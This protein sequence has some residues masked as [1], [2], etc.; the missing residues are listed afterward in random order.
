MGGVQGRGPVSYGI[1]L[2]V[3]VIL[4]ASVSE[5]DPRCPPPS[6]TIGMRLAGG[7]VNPGRR[8]AYIRIETKAGHG[9]GK[10]IAKIIE[11]QA[12]IYAFALAN[13]APPGA[14]P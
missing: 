10:P 3:A 7:M 13:L 11:E 5:S 12:D 9:A 2:K 4:T 8:P 6:C 1:W 14:V